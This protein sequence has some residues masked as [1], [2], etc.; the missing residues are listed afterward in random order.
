MIQFQLDLRV[1]YFYV[2]ENSYALNWNK[3]INWND[4]E[5][6]LVQIRGF[7]CITQKDVESF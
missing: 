7:P 4:M 3:L 6:H 2:I 5:E 1:C